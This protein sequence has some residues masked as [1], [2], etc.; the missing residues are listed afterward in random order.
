MNDVLSWVASGELNVTI[1]SITPLPQ[2][3]DTH[4]RLASRATIGKLLLKP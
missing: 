4:I 3:P 1:D 2:A